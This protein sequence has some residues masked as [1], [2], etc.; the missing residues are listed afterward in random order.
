MA[1][2]KELNISITRKV[3]GGGSPV[4]ED[5]H[6]SA[7][8]GEIVAIVGPSGAGKSTL[9]NIVSGLDTQIE[10]EVRVDGGESAG[11]GGEHRPRIGMMFQAPRLM[12]WLT[13]LENVQ[14]VLGRGAE[15][16]ERAQEALR[17]VGLEAGRPAF[18]AS[19]PGGKDRGQRLPDL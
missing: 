14:L 15:A 9:L 18:P 19:F 13:V 1:P 4:L 11:H 3:Y 6:V 2:V 12:P 7:R 17:D 10:G 8:A 5:L 16:M